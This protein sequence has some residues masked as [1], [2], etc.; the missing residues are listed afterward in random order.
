MSNLAV[1]FHQNLKDW[2]P[3]SNRLKAESLQVYSGE[4]VWKLLQLIE[5]EEEPACEAEGEACSSEWA[6]LSGYLRHICKKALT[7][8]SELIQFFQIL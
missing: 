7:A 5:R 4:L 6:G 2:N 1:N 8:K 3:P